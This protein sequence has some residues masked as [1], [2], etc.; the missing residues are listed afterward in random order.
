MRNV[1]HY[2]E[3]EESEM[4]PDFHQSGLGLYELGSQ[5]ATSR[6]EALLELTRQARSAAGQ[7]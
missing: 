4:F 7:A 3:E 1:E 6:V 2:V 5:V